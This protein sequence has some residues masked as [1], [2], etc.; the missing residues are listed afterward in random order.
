MCRRRQVGN[1]LWWK[2]AGGQG[3]RANERHDQE[4]RRRRERDGRSRDRTASGR[5]IKMLFAAGGL[6][7][8]APLHRRGPPRTATRITIS[9]F[10]G[11]RRVFFFF[12][13]ARRFMRRER[14]WPKCVIK[15]AN[16]NYE[17]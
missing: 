8:R 4:E 7:K 12:S 16:I 6:I 13:C 15:L 2:L 1:L 10:V 14:S 3:K 11:A 9:L 17:Y 5:Q